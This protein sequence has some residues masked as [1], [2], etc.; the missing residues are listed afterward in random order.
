VWHVY[1]VRVPQRDAVLQRLRQ[2]GI[3]AGVH[4]PTPIHL[5][6]AFAH[7]GH[8]AGDF[9]N[10]EDSARQIL[11]LPMFPGITADQQQRVVGE[12]R[13]ALDAV[14]QGEPR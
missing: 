7:L 3:G 6:P 14:A 5:Q 1:V 8:K 11:S 12:L 13:R 10:A 2:A 9:P 4:Y